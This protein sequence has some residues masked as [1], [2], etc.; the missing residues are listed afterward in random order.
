MAI[1]Y[2]ATRIM[3]KAVQSYCDVPQLWLEH[4]DRLRYFILKRVK[5]PEVTN[6]I[7][8]EVLL[9]VY[10]FCL[11]KSGVRN[12][13]SWLFQIAQNTIVDHFRKQSKFSQK[14]IPE[15]P[16]EE[17]NL[18]FKEAS[19]FIIPMLNFLPEKYA[20]PVRLSDV[21]GLRQTEIAN[22]LGLSLAAVKSR[23]RRGRQLL[24]AEFITC[25]N[26]EKD[27][28]GNLLSF[29]IKSSCSPLQKVKKELS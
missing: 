28:A 19:N 1:S 9:K 27:A 6:D 3:E 20:I 4:K 11:S 8:Q 25:C 2:N 21:E 5:D 14:E 24:M 13:S 12:V 29:D 15:L 22:K 23:I 26:F 7:L 18:A 10:K 17:E 16:G